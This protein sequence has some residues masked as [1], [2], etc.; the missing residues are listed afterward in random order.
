MF[1]GLTETNR[2][3]GLPCKMA[4]SFAQ[5]MWWLQQ[6]SAHSKRSPKYFE[7]FLHTRQFIVTKVGRSGSIPERESQLLVRDRAL[8]N[9]Q[10]S[11][12][13]QMPRLK[14]S[15]GGP[16]YGGLANTVGYTTWAR[17]LPCSI[18]RTTWVRSAS[19][20]SWHIQNWC[21]IFR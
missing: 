6:E 16:N 18:L 4:K 13:K 17:L 1:C 9:R 8:W 11:S 5:P 3:S 12:M 14:S 19:A 2:D 15:H 20:A 21:L 10:L 7:I